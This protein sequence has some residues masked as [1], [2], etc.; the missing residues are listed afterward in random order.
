MNK[1]VQKIV[2]NYLQNKNITQ[3]RK[4]TIVA[5]IQQAAMGA[6]MSEQAIINTIEKLLQHKPTSMFAY[7]SDTKCSKC[8]GKM[9]TVFVYDSRQADYCPRCRIALPK[10]VKSEN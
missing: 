3:S 1:N 2:K 7:S 4:N 6:P 8:Q 5:S 10:P 9:E